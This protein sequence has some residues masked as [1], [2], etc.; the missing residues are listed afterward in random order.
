MGLYP[1]ARDHST[2]QWGAHS[3][4]SAGGVFTALPELLPNLSTG[5]QDPNTA[6]WAPRPFF[7]TLGRSH[8]SQRRPPPLVPTGWSQWARGSLSSAQQ[9]WGSEGVTHSLVGGGTELR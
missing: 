9:A 1:W 2:G 5:P 7:P 4:A 8:I 6:P 3:G